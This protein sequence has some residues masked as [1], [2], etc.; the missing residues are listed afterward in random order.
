MSW[1]TPTRTEVRALIRDDINTNL[2]GADATIPNSVLRVLADGNAGLAHLEFLYLDYIAGEV[3]PDTTLD[4][5]DRHADIWLGG[6]KLATFASGFV[7]MTGTPGTLVPTGTSLSI[8]GAAYETTADTYI[9]DEATDVPVLALTAGRAGNSDPSTGVSVNNPV[10]GL[11][12]VAA[13]STLTGGVDIE[14]T[15]DLRIRLLERIRMPPMG[16]ARHDYVAWA[17]QVPGVTRAWAAQEMGIGTATLRFMMDDL[18][19]DFGGFPQ[20]ID[21]V[22]VFDH[23]DPLRPVT[24]KNFYVVAPVAFPIDFTVTDLDPD[25]EATRAAIAV[26]VEAMLK[27]KAAPGQTIFRAWIDEAVS[28]ALGEFSHELTFASTAMPS[29][30]HMAVLGTI[31]YA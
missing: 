18:R 8:S 28:R 1:Q 7:L 22:T 4:W 12:G 19:E 15:E 11:S 23:V 13:V 21:L 9:G 26:E 10:D 2:P 6:R 20:E 24:V 17:K 25:T 29:P 3:M 30:G 16:G 31:S 27:A 5:L 14:G